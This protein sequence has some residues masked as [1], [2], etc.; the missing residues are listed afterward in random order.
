MPHRVPDREALQD[1]QHGL[2]NLFGQEPM[3]PD[4]KRE[5]GELDQSESEDEHV[6]ARKDRVFPR[7]GSNC[8]PSCRGA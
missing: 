5:L 7:K 1:E 4:A 8:C 6:Q 3:E 2:Q